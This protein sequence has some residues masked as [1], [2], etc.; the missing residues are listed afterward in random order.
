MINGLCSG[1]G[2]YLFSSCIYECLSFS[3][4]LFNLKNN[5][6]D[7]KSKMDGMGYQL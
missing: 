4:E 6:G 2:N 7:E 5:Q 1:N 3:F